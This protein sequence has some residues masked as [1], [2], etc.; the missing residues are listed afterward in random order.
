MKKIFFIS[1]IGVGILSWIFFLS[2]FLL[3]LFP[4]SV[5]KAIDQYAL[6]SYSIDFSEL[7]NTGNALNQNF[8]FF[9]IHIMKNDS[10]ILK[11][12]ELALAASFKPQLF[13]QLISISS[14]TIKDGYFL[15]SEI[16]TSNS[17]Q[18][19]FVDLNDEVLLSFKNFKYQRNDSIIEING[20]LFGKLSSSL[21]GQLSFLHDNN[22]STVAVDVVED[23]YRFSLNLHSYKWL[24]L[25]PAFSASPIKDLTFQINALGELQNDQSNITGSFNSNNLFLNSSSIKPNI[26]LKR[27]R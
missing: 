3:T 15:H 9:D 25:I 19:F 27:S 4:A 6:P 18:N 16:S 2:L 10:S 22:L 1:T 26:Y 24:S 23:V 13:F 20:D 11:I 7:Q 14:I 8:K 17:F 12:K 21:S 5:I